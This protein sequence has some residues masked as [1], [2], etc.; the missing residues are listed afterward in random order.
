MT[1]ETHSKRTPPPN[2]LEA[3]RIAAASLERR[4]ARETARGRETG[5]GR[6]KEAGDDKRH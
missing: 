6:M 2:V 4:K 3:V 5:G 1:N